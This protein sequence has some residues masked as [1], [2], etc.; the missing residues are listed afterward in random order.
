MI[1]QE[2][3]WSFSINCQAM[4]G[5]TDQHAEA[6]DKSKTSNIQELGREEYQH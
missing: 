2:A 1:E 6:V 4:F 5:N 3:D